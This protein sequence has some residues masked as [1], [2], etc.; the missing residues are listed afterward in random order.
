MKREEGI[1][2]RQDLSAVTDHVN[3]I[4]PFTDMY[5]EKLRRRISTAVTR[6]KR[7]VRSLEYKLSMISDNLLE[8]LQR[9][10]LPGKIAIWAVIMKLSLS[11]QE[12]LVSLLPDITDDVVQEIVEPSMS[13][14]GRS[15]RPKLIALLS[16]SILLRPNTTYEQ[17]WKT[18]LPVLRNMA[19]D[20]EVKPNAL[21]SMHLLVLSIISRY[22]RDLGPIVRDVLPLILQTTTRATQLDKE[23]LIF[24]LKLLAAF[25]SHCNRFV[26]GI[27]ELLDQVIKGPF[28]TDESVLRAL[29]EFVVHLCK[30]IN[31]FEITIVIEAMNKFV[32]PL[33]EAH[34]DVARSLQEVRSYAVAF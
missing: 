30:W 1:S 24:G 13:I 34:I 19:A 22:K 16:Q 5:D 10:G 17:H 9:R 29:I 33:A 20:V 26:G 12:E 18:L 4:L 15:Y 21:W 6:D 28:A 14:G 2:L 3:T 32:K 11:I 23:T 27:G 25:Q 7:G 8:A 31:L